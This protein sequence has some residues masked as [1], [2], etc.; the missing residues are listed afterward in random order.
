MYVCV[1]VCTCMQC[2]FVQVEKGRDR[3]ILFKF[4][5]GST[6]TIFQLF[7]KGRRHERHTREIHHKCKHKG[8]VHLFR[9]LIKVN[10]DR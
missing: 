4:M 10:V 5:L 3:E 8:T 7:R 9:K 1:F 6:I 2:M